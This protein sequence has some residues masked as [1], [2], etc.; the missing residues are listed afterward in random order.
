MTV[1]LGDGTEI[2]A[3]YIDYEDHVRFCLDSAEL[4][5][6]TDELRSSRLTMR[7][8]QHGTDHEFNAELTRSLKSEEQLKHPVEFRALSGIKEVSK[9]E[10]LRISHS[11]KVSVWRNGVYKG[12]GLSNDL[13]KSGMCLWSDSELDEEIGT[14][15]ILEF[16]LSFALGSVF[17]I[18]AKLMR[19]QPN[20]STRSYR[21]EFGFLFAFRD[22]KEQDKLIYGMLETRLSS[23]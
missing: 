13:S 6:M 15:F 2:Q 20:S 8:F 4:F 1:I 10:S 14:E 7:F 16:T 3:L 11:V 9:R 22:T 5:A 18:P 23:R 17:K 12:E 21:N 19:S